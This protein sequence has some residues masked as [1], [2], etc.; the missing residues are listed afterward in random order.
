MASDVPL[1]ADFNDHPSIRKL[2]P[3]MPNLESMIRLIDLPYAGLAPAHGAI[4]DANQVVAY[5]NYVNRIA[6]GLGVELEDTWP[7]T[8]RMPRHRVPAHLVGGFPEVQ[9]ADLPWLTVGQMREVDRIMM[10][11]LGITLERM[12]E[13]AGRSLAQLARHQLGG[14]VG[15]R[16]VVVLAGSG[17]NGGGGMVAARYLAVA[18]AVVALSLGAPDERMAPVPAAQLSILRKMGVPVSFGR[19]PPVAPDLVI[20]ALLGYSQVGAPRDETAR[21]IEWTAGRRVLSVAVPSGLELESGQLFEPHVV[22]EATLTLA[23]PQATFTWPT[24]RFRRPSTKASVSPMTLH[25]AVARS[26]AW[27]SRKRRPD[28]VG[29]SRLRAMSRIVKT[30]HGL[31][32]S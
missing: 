24:S 8:W 10:E 9:E 11:E 31:S 23:L 18:G 22:A 6:H 16:H 30:N 32:L 17:G 12:M 20:D 28:D 4:V 26:C 7:A 1:L 15:G 2:D 5:F 29:S 14:A 13:N 25:L 19:E 3:A 27:H 21:L